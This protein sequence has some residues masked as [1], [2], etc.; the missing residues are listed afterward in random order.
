MGA[1]E[2][3]GGTITVSSGLIC[4]FRIWR[5]IYFKTHSGTPHHVLIVRTGMKSGYNTEWT[6]AVD[7]KVSYKT[8]DQGKWGCDEALFR[9]FAFYKGKEV[10]K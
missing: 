6:L 1:N 3:C 4:A 9:G 10:Y 2:M 5:F 8:P 7:K